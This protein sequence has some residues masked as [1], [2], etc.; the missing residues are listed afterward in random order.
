MATRSAN[1]QYIPTTYLGGTGGAGGSYTTGKTYISN[2]VLNTGTGGKN[3]TAEAYPGSYDSS[4]GTAVS[5]NTYNTK[6]NTSAGVNS[7]SSSGYS[8]GGSYDSGSSGDAGGDTYDALG[9]AQLEL[10]KA[11]AD[12]DYALSQEQL[13]MQKDAAAKEE[14]RLANIARN[15]SALVASYENQARDPN[16]YL[17]DLKNAALNAYN[18]SLS[19]LNNSY[20]QQ[21]NSLANILNQTKGQLE[22]NYNNARSSIN[23]EAENYLRQAYI[24]NMLSQKNLGQQLTAQGLSGGASES[25]L[26]GM[27]NN[28]GNIRNNI[29]TA[30]NNSI[31]SLLNNYNNSLA[32]ANQAYASAVDAAQQQ[33]AKYAMQLEDTLGSNNINALMEANRRRQEEEAARLALIENAISNGAD[34]G[35][36]GNTGNTNNGNSGNTGNTNN[37]NSGGAQSVNNDIGFDAKQFMNAIASTQDATTLGNIITAYYNIATDQGKSYIQDVRTKLRNKGLI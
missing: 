29:N 3:L 24:N 37:G 23:Q 13:Q 20:N 28:Y 35:S 2:G 4:A 36:T 30:T 6:S 34:I 31:T 17:N 1:K 27:A 11:N 12:R 8:S 21:I 32:D 14:A 18:S 22:G 5:A 19:Q 10:Q 25:T 33:R 15:Y 16:G 7:G 26:A 9:W